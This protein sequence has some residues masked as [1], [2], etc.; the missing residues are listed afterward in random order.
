MKLPGN[1][2]FESEVSSFSSSSLTVSSA[3]ATKTKQP[4]RASKKNLECILCEGRDQT[5]PWDG[6]PLAFIISG[7]EKK[8]GQVEGDDDAYL[9]LTGIWILLKVNPIETFLR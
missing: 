2:K 3:N 7:W 6:Y 9:V 1:W 5:N 8:L 4:K